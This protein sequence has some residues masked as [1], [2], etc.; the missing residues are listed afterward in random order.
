MLFDIFITSAWTPHFSLQKMYTY[1]ES[2]L[3]YRSSMIQKEDAS[4]RRSLFHTLFSH[5]IVL[6]QKVKF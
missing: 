6:L 3:H 4:F 1:L 2:L 5:K